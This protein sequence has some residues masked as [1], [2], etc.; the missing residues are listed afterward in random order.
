[1]P[2]VDAIVA[3]V[4]DERHGLFARRRIVEA[5]V[6][7]EHLQRRVVR[8]DQVV[9]IPA[10]VVALRL[11]ALRTVLDVVVP[12]HLDRCPGRR[13]V[14]DALLLI[15]DVRQE[16]PLRTRRVVDGLSA[17]CFAS[18]V[19]QELVIGRIVAQDLA[20]L[21]LLVGRLRVAWVLEIH[22]VRALDALLDALRKGSI[23]ALELVD[24]AVR[25]IE[26]ADWEH[27]DLLEGLRLYLRILIHPDI[28]RRLRRHERQRG[29]HQAAERQT[30]PYSSLTNHPRS[31]NPLTWLA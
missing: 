9:G 3:V 24:A 11:V 1:M 12:L 25:R 16:I 19:A 4:V 20:L 14:V 31:S 26:V 10:L 18:E 30:A 7:V 5:E 27:D 13:R 29:R 22:E 17:L 8:G 28:A 15:A 23:V 2:L 6:H 21:A